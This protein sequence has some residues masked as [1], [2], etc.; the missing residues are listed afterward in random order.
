MP[1]RKKTSPKPE[2]TE[3]L[4]QEVREAF[5]LFDTDGSGHIDVKELKVFKIAPI[6]IDTIDSCNNGLLLCHHWTW[7][8]ADW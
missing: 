2:L 4:R 1:Q 7:D 5:E 8:Q 3:E 6:L